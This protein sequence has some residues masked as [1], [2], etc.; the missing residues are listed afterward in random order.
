MTD[1]RVFQLFADDNYRFASCS[2]RV[3]DRNRG[4]DDLLVQLYRASKPRL[5]STF[6][7]MRDL[8]PA[9]VTAYLSTRNPLLL[10]CVDNPD[11]DSGSE[12]IGYAFLTTI[13]GPAKG[14]VNPDPGRTA[15]LGYTMFRPWWGRPEI[16]VC[17]MLC[18]IYF[19]HEFNLLTL[20]GESVPGNELT[21]RFLRQF[22]TKTTG[23]IPKFLLHGG[24]MV[25]CHISCLYRADLESY[26]RKV[27]SDC[28]SQYDSDPDPVSPLCHVND[29]DNT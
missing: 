2:V 27:L 20:Q 1:D 21:R 12:I 3:Y 7:N 15:F 5:S 6:C 25:D 19:F 4:P 8:S 24:V 22:G 26:C 11:I 9:A 13:A 17:M 29:D 10:M 23:I 28:T 14:T 18:G 16:T